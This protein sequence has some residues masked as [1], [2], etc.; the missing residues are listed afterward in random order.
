MAVYEFKVSDFRA[1]FPAFA[2]DTKYPDTTITQA[3]NVVVSFF[4]NTDSSVFPYDPENGDYTRK[5]LIDFG[6]CHLLTLDDQP[7]DQPGRIASASEGSVSTSFDLMKANSTVGDWWAQTKCGRLV[8]V[9]LAPFIYGVRIYVQSKF[10][11]WG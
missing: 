11:P 5:R 8:W 9:L 4:Q 6:V 7:M 2:D 1:E 10:H 3:Y